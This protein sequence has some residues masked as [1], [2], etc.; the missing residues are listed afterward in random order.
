LSLDSETGLFNNYVSALLGDAADAT[1]RWTGSEADYDE[2]IYQLVFKS[3]WNGVAMLERPTFKWLASARD[4]S[5]FGEGRGKTKLKSV[6]T[7]PVSGGEM[8]TFAN[9]IRVIYKKMATGGKFAY[10]M[11]IKGGFS[12]VKDLSSGEGAFFSDMMRFHRVANLPA[13]EFEKVLKANG[14]DMVTKVS[15]SDLRVSGSSPSNQYALVF[16]SLLSLANDR[17][18]DPSGFE[19]YRRLERAR[20]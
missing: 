12:T 8:W 9:G 6:S 20:R 1:V 4:T 15:S 13:G 19:P 18:A 11:M 7:E 3:T 17:K 14:V 2:W 10:S 5:D 16:K